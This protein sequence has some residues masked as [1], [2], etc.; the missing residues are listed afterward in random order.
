[1]RSIEGK[2]KS[3]G[4]SRVNLICGFAGV[5]ILVKVF[6]KVLLEGGYI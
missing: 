4:V 3:A 5:V 1:M 6:S 2:E